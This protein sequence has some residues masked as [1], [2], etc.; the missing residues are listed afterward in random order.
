[1]ELLLWQEHF[2]RVP[3]GDPT[4]H[5]MLGNIGMMIETYM[6]GGKS[7]ADFHAWFPWLKPRPKK[8]KR[9]TLTEHQRNMLK[10]ALKSA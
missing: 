5:I 7:R 8:S 4:S 1:M 2:K 10:I 6:L 9:G 3:V